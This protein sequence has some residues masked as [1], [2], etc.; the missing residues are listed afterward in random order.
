[1]GG[2]LGDTVL[3][4]QDAES[5]IQKLI[6]EIICTSS[7]YKSPSLGFVSNNTFMN[8]VIELHTQQTPSELHIVTQ[9][10]ERRIGRT[11][12][13]TTNYIDRIIDLDILYY[14]NQIINDPQLTIP[15]PRMHERNF[16][17][18]PLNECW[19]E[20]KHPVS[21]KTTAELLMASNDKSQLERLEDEI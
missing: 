1:M 16:V 10:I 20:L 11:N 17:L 19:P 5:L 14:N 3:Y 6:G 15:H 12:N 9:D 7:V 4:F 2:N 8:K 18:I 21:E 13:T